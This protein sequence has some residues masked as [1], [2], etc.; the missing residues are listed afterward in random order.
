MRHEKIRGV[1]HIYVEESETEQQVLRVIVKASF[2]LARPAG[3]GWMNFNDSEEM[4]E[5]DADNFVSLPPSSGNTVVDMDYIQ[6]RQCKTT[7]R[8]KSDGHFIL[9]NGRYERDRGVPEPMLDRAK[10]ILAGK[11]TVGLPPSGLASTS[12][13]YKGESLTLRLKEYGYSRREGESDW[14]FR[15]RIFPDLYQRDPDRA[16]EFLIG[17]SA[18]EWD[19]INKVLCLGFLSKGKPSQQ[20]LVDF[21][22]GFTDDPLVMREQRQSAPI[23]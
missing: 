9:N 15:K 14:D 16:M 5:E 23:N 7:L 20:E 18:A 3:L 13:M 10:E 12:H 19:E 6:G 2:E 21:A 1:T 11:E 22:E 8:K 4:T 17:G